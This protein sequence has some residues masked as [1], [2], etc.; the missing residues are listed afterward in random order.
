MKFLNFVKNLT[1]EQKI[2]IVMSVVVIT[3]IIVALEVII[4]TSP[5]AQ[6]DQTI[7]KS[8]K[9]DL[10]E[11][12]IGDE[13]DSLQGTQIDDIE[14][15]MQVEEAYKRYLMVDRYVDSSVGPMPSLLTV[16]GLIENEELEKVITNSNA[17]DAST[18][19]DS[20]VNYNTF[21]NE[22]LTY[23]TEDYF[24]QYF[25]DY[26]NMDGNVGVCNCAA[27]IPVFEV[28][29]CREI[30]LTNDVYACKMI[31]KDTE[32]Y[33]HFLVEGESEQLT[34]QSCF[35]G[36]IVN[37]KKVNDRMV[38]DHVRKYDGKVEVKEIAVVMQDAEV[39][40]EEQLEAEKVDAE[41][42]K[43][44]AATYYIKVNYG[45]NTV[46]VY[47]K[48]EAGEYTVPVKAMICSCGIS[49]PKSGVY[50]TSNGYRW[51]TLIG[52]VYGQYSTRIVGNILFHS[53]P[54]TDNSPDCLEYWEFD[55][56]G[57]SAS[58][59]CVRL[60]VADARWI[61]NN[62]E[63]GTMVE[64]YSSGDPGPL[65]KP[66]APK[67]T[68]NERCRNWDPTDTAE[69]NP[70]FEEPEQVPAEPA[71]PEPTQAPTPEPI[72]T[73]EPVKEPVKEPEKPV[74]QTKPVENTTKPTPKPEPDKVENTVTPPTNTTVPTKPIEDG[75]GE[76][77]TP[78]NDVPGTGEQ[79][80]DPPETPENPPEAPEDPEPEPPEETPET[81]ETPEPEVPG[82]EINNEVP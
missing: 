76:N 38:V 54:Y 12:K 8:A 6:I 43:T 30:K 47:G 7:T 75:P 16:L 82:E 73:P 2:L 35:V 71:N 60:M 59:G 51:G 22:M 79:T 52:G 36:Q 32:M 74:N 77:Q 80:E 3:A 48:D 41:Q 67:I 53:V 24:E 78:V 46:T 29:E 62:C 68:G 50:K 17:Q 33:E 40:S 39:T 11:P 25:S 20:T 49:T 69:G 4:A 55:K 15:K 81:P 45:A 72:P 26:K 34:Y 21:K 58:A 31:M 65:G 66:S 18:Y 44:G 27:G 28:A 37:F 19:I 57:T 1:K 23:M 13:Y 70:W 56:L 61:F 63:R 9:I 10:I 42:V 5:N 64:F 14:M